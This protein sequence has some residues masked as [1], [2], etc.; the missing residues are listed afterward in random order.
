MSAPSK[1]KSAS[2][3]KKP[4]PPLRAAPPKSKGRA[5]APA[6]SK[7]KGD[8]EAEIAAAP[9][10]RGHQDEAPEGEVSLEELEGAEPGGLAEEGEEDAEEAKEARPLPIPRGG[11]AQTPAVVD[12]LTA[13]MRE[14][15]RYPILSREE[16]HRLALRWHKHK[17]QKAAIQL[18]TSNLKLVVKIAWEY[19]S[20]H[21]NL[22][23]LVQ[24]GNI[25]L[26][27]AVRAFDP[28]KGVRL[29][30]Y[31]QYWIRAYMLRYIINNFHLVKLGT[32][33]AQRKLFFNLRKEKERLE[34]E[35]FVPTT[36]LLAQKLDVKEEEVREM[37]ARLSGGEVSLDAPVSTEE[38][39]ATLGNFI[40]D[41]S[42]SAESR[43]AGDEQMD[44][45]RKALGEYR[46]RLDER[47]GFIFDKR[48]VAEKPLTLEEVGDKFGVSKERARQLEERIKANLRKFLDARGQEFEI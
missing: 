38:E 16:E 25:G 14:A 17:D 15:N 9:E 42:E 45:F 27:M 32:T 6:R 4:P 40:A 39:S 7:R 31:A 8:G 18:V 5:K 2:G 43:V 22:L 35:G 20:A 3:G 24:E 28:Y 21:K 19:R 10:E 26:L 1:K 36:K 30:S 48:L 46:K 47:D 41:P 44:R 12:T 29:S 11:G 23:D 37:D 13:Y 34:R 33:Q